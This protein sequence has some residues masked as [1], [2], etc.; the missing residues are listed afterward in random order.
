M[1]TIFDKMDANLM[2]VFKHAEERLKEKYP[3]YKIYFYNTLARYDIDSK[4]SMTLDII[5]KDTNVTFQYDENINPWAY[6]IE[7]LKLQITKTYNVGD[8]GKF[9]NPYPGY[10]DIPIPV[11]CFDTVMKNLDINII[12]NEL[13]DIEDLMSSDD[14]SGLLALTQATYR[15]ISFLLDL[16]KIPENENIHTKIRR[17]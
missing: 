14:R 3:C 15:K 8:K 7:P 9:R 10:C 2:T 16:A 6:T 12:F 1:F 13:Q 4:Q 5:Y 17:P 11:K